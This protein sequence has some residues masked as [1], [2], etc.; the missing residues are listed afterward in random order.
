MPRVLRLTRD[1]V[2]RLPARVDERGPVRWSAPSDAYYPETAATIL[3]QLP[4]DGQ[5]WVFAIGSLIWSGKLPAVE[6]RPAVI[7]GWH[8]A[9]CLGPDRRFRG[10]PAA[11]GLMMSLDR[12]GQCQGIAFRLDPTNLP[13]SLEAL[14]RSEPPMPPRW[15]T[16]RTPQ[17]TVKAIAFALE[18]RH[19]M[20][21]GRLSEAEVADR[22]ASAVGHVGT[23]AEYLLNTVIHL[24]EAGIHDRALW[25]MQAMVAER[26]ERLPAISPDNGLTSGV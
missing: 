26:L 7:R 12:G 4:E 18:R 10:S 13:A 15:V 5:F 8:R 19:F 3:S 21:A 20:Y 17:G 22:L 6:R 23:M 1:L 14:L 24:E 25:R 2:D 11:P 9:F 16:A